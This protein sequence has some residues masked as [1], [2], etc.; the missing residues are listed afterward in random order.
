MF[1]QLLFQTDTVN[2][3]RDLKVGKQFLVIIRVYEPFRHKIGIRNN[4]PPRCNQEIVLLGHQMLSDLRDKI[5]CPSDFAVAGELSE[6]PDADLTQRTMVSTN[7]IPLHII[8][9]MH[10]DSIRSIITNKCTFCISVTLFTL[11]MFRLWSSHH[12]GYTS[13]FTSLALVHLVLSH[14]ITMFL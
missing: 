2:K 9:T 8:F 6:N 4:H 13:R 11:H 5:H 12:Q 10:F 3:A 14:V 7:F 1:F